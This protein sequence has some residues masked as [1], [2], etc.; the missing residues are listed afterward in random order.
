MDQF[1]RWPRSLRSLHYYLEVS[2]PG[3]TS[4]RRSTHFHS[5]NTL[6][7][8]DI[9]NGK[10]SHHFDHQL[11]SYLL[12]HQAKQGPILDKNPPWNQQRAPE[13]WPKRP[14][15]ENHLPTTFFCRSVSFRAGKPGIC[16]KIWQNIN[17]LTS[18]F[19][20]HLW[21]VLHRSNGKI[22]IQPKVP[23]GPGELRDSQPSIAK[24]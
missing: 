9:S 2:A 20:A 7:L 8:S 21:I 24:H 16:W 18:L 13:N 23:L 1:D 6:K 14:K 19:G 11:I 17:R 15:K 3:W 5:T 4:S 22:H 10:V 12:F